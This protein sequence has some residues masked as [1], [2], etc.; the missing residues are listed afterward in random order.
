MMNFCSFHTSIAIA[1]EKTADSVASEAAHNDQT[2]PLS[3]IKATIAA[4]WDYCRDERDIRRAVR[5]LAR[6]DDH[7]LRNIGIRDRS[8]IEFTVRFCRKC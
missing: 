5:A 1:P 8:E 2:G 6:L 7:T 4:L 3:A